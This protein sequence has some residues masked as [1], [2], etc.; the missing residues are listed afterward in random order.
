[1]ILWYIMNYIFLILCS[2]FLPIGS[3]KQSKPKLCIN[4]KHFVL[5]ENSD[6]KFGKCSLFPSNNGKLNFLVSGVNNDEYHYCST[7]R[8][9]KD[10]CSEEGKY[11]KKKINKNKKGEEWVKWGKWGK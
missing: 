8:S 4:C 3:L 5:D 9:Q 6:S 1:M 2:I 11:Y 10:M 7:V